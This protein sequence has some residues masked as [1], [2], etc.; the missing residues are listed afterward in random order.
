SLGLEII[1]IPVSRHHRPLED[2]FYIFR[3]YRVLRKIK[4][5]IVY[6]STVKPNTYGTIAA[7][8]AGVPKIVS[9]VAGVGR[10]FDPPG[11]F[12][13]R[14]IHAIIF[15]LYRKAGHYVDKMWFQNRD[16]LELFCRRKIV[17]REKCLLI[18]SSGINT[19]DFSPENID[20]E[21]IV[22]LR[23]EFQLSEDTI[24][25]TMLSRIDL[26]KGVAEFIEASQI[27][28]NWRKNVSFLLA[29]ERDEFGLN[30][31][32][33]KQ[34]EPTETFR[35]VGKRTD[36]RN[37]L[38][39]SDIVTLPS[40]HEGVPRS[41][42]EGMAMGKPVVTTDAPGCRETVEDSVNGFLVPV[43]NS[44]L[45]AKALYDLV[46]DRQKRE[47]FGKA[48]L[49]KVRSE[50]SCKIVHQRVLEELFGIENPV[51][52]DIKTRPDNNGIDLLAVS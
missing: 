16:D 24:V 28:G 31:V 3:L 23:N 40:Y 6:T 7:R 48:G 41:L 51:I 14:I 52:P 4:P 20:R 50:F 19:N 21:S 49:S 9:G 25:I 12:Q 39:V 29:G 36:I 44:E 1:S 46:I 5:D 27:A 2:F 33:D 42:L 43:K 17:P 37:I 38:A 13:E 15:R 26:P 47:A 30:A 11:S 10:S 35:Y 34:L 32:S 45:L 18:R 22:R 8:W